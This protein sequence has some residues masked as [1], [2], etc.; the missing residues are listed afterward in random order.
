MKVGLTA[1]KGTVQKALA[2]E[3]YNDGLFDISSALVR[4]GYDEVGLDIG[5]FL[6]L[7]K[8]GAKITDSIEELFK[9]SDVVIDFSSPELA[10]KAASTASKMNKTVIIGT[11]F[12]TE[13]ELDKLKKYSESCRILYSSNMSITFN[14]L[15]NITELAS[16]LLRDDYNI[17]VLDFENI[18]NKSGSGMSNEI[19]K[20]VATGRGWEFGEVY[21]KTNGNGEN[22]NEK[23]INFASL[24]GG[25]K[26]GKY[27]VLFNGVGEELRITQSMTSFSSFIKGVKRALIWLDGK[28]NGLYTMKD[29]LKLSK[30]N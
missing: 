29:V 9:K 12:L 16:S 8:I 4:Q 26:M 2:L 5:T 28:Q 30:V 18:T 27:E 11:R 23:Q 7:E 21:K 3:L 22:I 20:A 13:E 24:R 19:A 10:L 25:D 1:I 14:L 6:G 17:N 15:L